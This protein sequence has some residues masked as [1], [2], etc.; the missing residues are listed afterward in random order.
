MILKLLLEDLK[1]RDH[2]KDLGVDER[3]DV[4]EIGGKV[5]TGVICFRLGTSG[6]LL[7]TQ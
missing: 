5:W 7:G 4:R 2:L 1:G 6:G 3:R